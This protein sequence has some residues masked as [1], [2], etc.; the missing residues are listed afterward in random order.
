MLLNRHDQRLAA[1]MTETNHGNCHQ[2]EQKKV[3]NKTKFAIA[4]I[5]WKRVRP[6]H[7]NISKVNNHILS[8]PSRY[9]RKDYF[10]QHGPKNRLLLV[11]YLRYTDYFNIC[12]QN[13][14]GIIWIFLDTQDIFTADI[15]LLNLSISP[16]QQKKRFFLLFI[17][18]FLFL[19]GRKVISLLLIICF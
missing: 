10:E 5:S 15:S 2:C 13:H 14:F 3:Y 12:S 4:M 9:A 16:N 11:T 19:S 17:F 8:V 1:I 6:C 18:L 7:K